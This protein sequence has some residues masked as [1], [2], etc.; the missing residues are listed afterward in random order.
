MIQKKKIAAHL[1]QT[2]VFDEADKMLEQQYIEE[3]RAVLKKCM[4]NVQKMFFSASITED[5]WRSIREIC[6][7]VR[8]LHVKQENRIPKNIRHM[9]I[10][11]ENRDKL[12]VLRSV[13][14]AAR[15][16]KAMVFINKVY[17]I[18][19]ATKKLQYH[20]YQADCIHGSQRK[21]KRKDV[22]EKFHQ[23]RL[24]ILIGTDMAA[25]GLHFENVD[26][27]V[28]YSIPEETGVYL[29][30][31]GRTGRNGKDGRSLSIVTKK[32]LAFIKMCKKEFGIVMQE[33][34][35]KNGMI[36]PRTFTPNAQKN[37]SGNTSKKPS[38]NTYKNSS[39]N[40]P[41]KSVEKNLQKRNKKLKIKQKNV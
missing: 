10:V 18:E 2:V 33:C 4:R 32:E 23:G 11:C 34:I 25:R 22:V 20:N 41:H 13:I 37:S 21:D 17:D 1:I 24:K 28:H 35:L 7:E 38:G 27:V 12:Q 30:R 8:D 36:L 40:T 31:A 19:E 16:Q 3:S 26:L 29:H 9:Y 5:A 39:G 15:P 14:A 6:P